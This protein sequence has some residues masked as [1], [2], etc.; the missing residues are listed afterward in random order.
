M[1]KISSINGTPFVWA[2]PKVSVSLIT[3]KAKDLITCGKTL[4]DKPV[5][6]HSATFAEKFPSVVIS[7]AP[8][9]VNRKKFKM[10]FPTAGAGH[11]PLAVVIK[12]FLFCLNATFQVICSEF[13]LIL[14]CP[15][16]A[17][18][19]MFSPKYWLGVVSFFPPFL[20]TGLADSPV[21]V[22]I[23]KAL[24]FQ[25]FLTDFGHRQIVPPYYQFNHK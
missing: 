8:D 14:A 25:A 17:I 15:I 2:S 23:S 7:T 22:K 16:I 10:I 9:M 5:V 12:N 19:I 21:R 18:R 1:S 13:I 24:A 3:V 11:S 4:L 6:K 20:Y